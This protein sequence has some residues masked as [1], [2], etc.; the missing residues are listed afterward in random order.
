[1]LRNTAQSWG[2]LAR[3]LH[4]VVAV[5]VLVQIALGLTAAAWR[6]SPLKLELF[7]W[8]KSTGFLILL[9]VLVRLAWRLANPTPRLPADMPAWERAAAR[10]SHG[11]FYVLL[12]ALPVNG[13]VINSA[14]NVP[15][16]IFWVLPLPAIV[17]PDRALQGAAETGHFV[18]FMLLAVLVVVH[19]GAA[20]RHHFVRRDCVL[21]NMLRGGPGG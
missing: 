17:A 21:L 10:A 5:L 2:S 3:L 15:F 19:A 12:I 4:W 18:M 14:A 11:L 6:L 9:L 20:L 1:M 13:W 7:V 8:H 16:S